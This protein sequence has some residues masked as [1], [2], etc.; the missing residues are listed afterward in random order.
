[1]YLLAWHTFKVCCFITKASYK[2]FRFSIILSFE[3]EDG[4][5]K[6][7]KGGSARGRRE[8][9]KEEEKEGS[10]GEK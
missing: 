4:W 6:R 2:K 3:Y 7:K 10:K 1:M 5:M 8:R 9:T